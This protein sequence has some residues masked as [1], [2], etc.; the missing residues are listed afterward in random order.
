MRVQIGLNLILMQRS[1]RSG[2]ARMDVSINQN[3]SAALIYLQSIRTTITIC[4]SDIIRKRLG[5]SLWTPFFV[6][7]K[8][9]MQRLEVKNVNS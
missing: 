1:L 7:R 4:L 6:Y 2:C 8:F 5:S 3:K 9:E